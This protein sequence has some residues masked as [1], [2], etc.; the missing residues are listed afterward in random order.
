MPLAFLGGM[1]SPQAQAFPWRCLYA[2]VLNESGGGHERFCYLV[3]VSKWSE[4][5]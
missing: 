1:L 5:L 4:T 2:H 3:S